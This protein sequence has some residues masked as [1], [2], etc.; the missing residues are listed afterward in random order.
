[1]LHTKRDNE[2]PSANCQSLNAVGIRVIFKVTLTGRNQKNGFLKTISNGA[3]EK[4]CMSYCFP[5][6][7]LTWTI[8]ATQWKFRIACCWNSGD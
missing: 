4:T 3:N 2:T 7:S 5:E 6:I 1:M 8:P